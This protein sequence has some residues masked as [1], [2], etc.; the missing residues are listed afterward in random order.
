MGYTHYLRGKDKKMP[1]GVFESVVREM[2]E[3][4]VWLCGDDKEKFIGA[5]DRDDRENPEMRWLVDALKKGDADALAERAVEKGHFVLTFDGMESVYVDRDDAKF[6]FCKTFHEE[7]GDSWVVALFAAAEAASGGWLE[8]T[9]DGYDDELAR[10]RELY[11]KFVE[12]QNAAP[13]A[14]Q[15]A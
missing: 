10:G 15:G 12:E 1:G 3:V 14:A 4:A 6:S 5:L 8:M 11:E 7:P 2:S 13:T 9:S